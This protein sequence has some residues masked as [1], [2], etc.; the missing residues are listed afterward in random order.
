MSEMLYFSRVSLP[1]PLER[2]VNIQFNSFAP[3]G[4]VAG[5]LDCFNL[6]QIFSQGGKQMK[7]KGSMRSMNYIHSDQ[8]VVELNRIP[9]SDN[10]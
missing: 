7:N 9:N 4:A 5:F 1:S 6:C 3:S 8:F 2:P 10:D